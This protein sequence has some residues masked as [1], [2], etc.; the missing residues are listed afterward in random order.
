MGEEGQRVMRDQ[1]V[2][3]PNPAGKGTVAAIFLTAA[4]AQRR[5]MFA[6]VRYLEGPEA[7]ASARVPYAEITVEAASVSD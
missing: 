7:G 2:R 1:R 5:P 4:E 6:W 3:V